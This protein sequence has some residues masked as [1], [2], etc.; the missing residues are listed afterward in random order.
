MYNNYS[1]C[2]SSNFFSISLYEILRLS[3]DETS[4]KTILAP[5]YFIA[6][7]SATKVSDGQITSSPFFTPIAIRL[8]CRAVV[9]LDTANA[10]LFLGTHFF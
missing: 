8:K 1:F 10:N 2:F 3:W 9:Q 5:V 4:H 7:A 6:L